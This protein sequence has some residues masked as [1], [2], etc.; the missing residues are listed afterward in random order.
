MRGWR[1][2]G[3]RLRRGAE[4]RLPGRGGW[5]GGRAARPGCFALAREPPLRVHLF[6]LGESEHVI[7]LLLHHIAGDGWSLAPLLRALGR[8]YEARG[9]GQAAAVAALPVQYADYTLWQHAVLG[10]EDDGESA[11]A[12]QLSFW[13]SQLSGLPAPLGSPLARARPAGSRH[14]GGTV[15]LPLS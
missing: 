5:R 8:F 3:L 15:A 6:A 14:R 13:T 4:A 11:I 9:R 10:S 7:L 2:R 1:D 12:R